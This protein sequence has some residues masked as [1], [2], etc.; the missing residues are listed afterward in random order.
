[1]LEL[2][3]GQG[4]VPHP[5]EERERDYGPIPAFYIGGARHRLEDAKD[6]LHGRHRAFARALG[7]PRFLLGEAEIIGVRIADPGTVSGLARQPE[8]EGSQ[9][10]EGLQDGGLAERPAGGRARRLGQVPPES[11]GLLDVESSKVAKSGRGSNRWIALT[12][13]SRLASLSPF[14]AFR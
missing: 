3:R 12:T 5:R 4:A 13:V 9:G 2:E 11:N 14:A 10:V 7:D 1:M 8:E 6:L